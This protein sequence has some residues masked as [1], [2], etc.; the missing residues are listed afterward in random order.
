MEAAVV[1]DV[2]LYGAVALVLVVAAVIGYFALTRG[3][4]PKGT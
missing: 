4:K 1:P 2:I 3:R